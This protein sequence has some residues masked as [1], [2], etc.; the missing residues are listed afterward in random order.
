MD[1]INY[2]AAQLAYEMDAAELRGLLPTDQHL[3]LIDARHPQAYTLAHLPGAISL[4]ARQLTALSTGHLDRERL[5]ICYGD[6]AGC[7][8][9]QRAALK[10]VQLGYTVKTL[11]GG[12]DWWQRQGYPLEGLIA[13]PRLAMAH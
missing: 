10:L 13:E 1:Q 6:G 8:A 7:Q 3:A 5:Y 4:P 9:A 11:A 2:Y 12:M